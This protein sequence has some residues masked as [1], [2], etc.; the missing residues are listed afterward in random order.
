[1]PGLTLF[2][3]G[4]ML[5]LQPVVSVFQT[6]GS[7]DDGA[8]DRWLANLSLPQIQMV[9]RC[10]TMG[11]LAIALSCVVNAAPQPRFSTAH[12]FGRV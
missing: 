11:V 1:M 12:T 5:C 7:L 10:V 6:Q 2:L 9:Q 4:V 8:M 3:I